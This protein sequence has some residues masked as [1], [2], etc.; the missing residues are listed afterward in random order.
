MPFQG[1]VSD[2]DLAQLSPDGRWIAY[3]SD[4]S[5]R[6]EV[7]VREFSLGSGGKPEATG[8]HQIS[9]GGGGDPQWRD[10][11]KELFY[12][13]LDRRTVM[14]AEITT[15]PGFQSLPGKMLF[16][17]PAV[18]LFVAPAVTGDGKR[19]LVA[20]PVGQSGLRQFTVVQNWQAELKK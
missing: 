12:M 19:F 10:D 5:G 17:L 7:Y 11:G 6:V 2:Y 15:K 3:E 4:E 9:N 13:T 8:K 16:Q 18:L 20:V 14:S 1:A